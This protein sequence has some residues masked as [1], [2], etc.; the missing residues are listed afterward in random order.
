MLSSIY[1][2]IHL[3]LWKTI[4]KPMNVISE[5]ISY[6]S[7]L[8][9]AIS[10]AALIATIYY[11]RKQT[12]LQQ[13]QIIE[14]KKQSSIQE[15][16]QVRDSTIRLHE[17]L[18]PLMLEEINN[19]INFREKINSMCKDSIK[20]I[21]YSHNLFVNSIENPEDSETINFLEENVSKLLRDLNSLKIEDPR[22]EKYES[23]IESIINSMCNSYAL[24]E[25]KKENCQVLDEIHFLQKHYGNIRD[26]ELYNYI[27]LPLSKDIKG[28]ELEENSTRIELRNL[29]NTDDGEEISDILDK[30]SFIIDSKCGNS[31]C[32][33]KFPLQDIFEGKINPLKDLLENPEDFCKRNE[34]NLSCKEYVPILGKLS[35]VINDEDKSKILYSFI[36]LNWLSTKIRGIL[37]TIQLPFE[38]DL[39][40]RIRAELERITCTE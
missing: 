8:S 6:A 23:Y 29:F 5:I 40:V 26:S 25:V 37:N 2:A 21:I 22:F 39:R 11:Y 14:L 17:V 3:N 31:Q 19:I 32:S 12:Q 16:L 34:L 36:Y 33:D 18:T 24:T 7:G 4:L 35:T 9:S 38:V 30:F 28:S 1:T 15:C 10:T 13:T 20:C 27:D